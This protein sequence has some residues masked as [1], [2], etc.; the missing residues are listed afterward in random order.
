MKKCIGIGV[1]LLG[2]ALAVSKLVNVIKKYNKESTN[3]DEMEMTS[4]S[5]YEDELAEIQAKHDAAMEALEKEDAKSKRE[6][7]KRMDD[8][9]KRHMEKMAEMDKIRDEL[10]TNAALYRY[11]SPDEVKKLQER[12][13]ELLQKL[14]EIK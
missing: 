4:S 11:A 5:S 3:L 13:N 9:R 10:L 12:D 6:H 1:A 2:C 7:Q 14:R 8:M